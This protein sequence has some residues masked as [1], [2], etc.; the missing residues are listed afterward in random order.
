[1][2]HFKWFNSKTAIIVAGIL[3]SAYLILI[4]TVTNLGQSRLKESQNS[5]LNLR[6]SNYTENLSFF[7]DA[8][9]K[10]IANLSQ[11]R[12]VNTYFSNLAAGMSLQYGLGSSLF[13]LRRTID[14]F[15]QSNKMD[16]QLIYSRV[17]IVGLGETVIVDTHPEVDFEVNQL[18]FKEMETVSHKVHLVTDESGP[19]IQLLQ[20]IYHQNKPVAILVASLNTDLVIRMLSTQEHLD[21]GSCLTL[22]TPV[23]D[24]VVWNSLS[25]CISDIE[26]GTT[27]YYSDS[28]RIIYFE[29][30]VVATPFKLESWF[31]PVTEQDIF[32][33]AWFIAAISLLALPV[34]MGLIYLMRVNNANLV[35]Q[36]QVEL[37]SEQQQELATQNALLHEEICK[38]K[39]SESK[40]AYQ[41]THDE[42]TNLANRTHGMA[43]LQEAIRAAHEKQTQILLLFIDL[44]NFKQVND[45]V[46]HHAG[47]LLLKQTSERLLTSVRRSDIV[48]RLGGDEFLVIVPDI[49]HQDSAKL[50]ASSILSV[51]EKP[52]HIEQ[53]EFFVSTSIGMSIYPKDGRNAATLLKRADTALYKVK[54]LGRNGFS[55]YDESMNLDV[56]RNFALNVRLHQAVQ[57][58]DIEIYYQP[59][60]DLTSRKIVAAEAL[61]RWTDSEL[62]YV[63]PEDFIPL[64][65]KNGLIHRLGD[66]VLLEACTQ[67]ASWQT[68]SPIKIAINF[69]S[70]QFRYCEQLQSRIVDVLMQTGLPAY[71]L[72]MEVTESLLIDQGHALMKML[73]YLKQ[74]GVGLSIDDFGTGYSALSYLQR[75]SFTKLKIDRA[76][77]NNMTT[78]SSDASLVSAI[79][80]MAKSL[81]LKVVAE[82][83]EN[84]QQALF[85][86]E[87]RC[88]YGQGYL[89]SRP[90]PAAEFTQLLLRDQKDASLGQQVERVS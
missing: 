89:F 31:E 37:S 16:G 72:D 78:C 50:V 29:K 12:D 5:A 70:V 60:L 46:G 84:E 11:K 71:Q 17:M 47:D 20:T 75:F 79:L 24:I 28:S 45:T 13:S 35:L 19:V 44:D 67:A 83:I 26:R 73:S 76:F 9:E 36:T 80:A 38:R 88:E 61:M 77:I 55:F 69:S 23:G 14:N 59:I 3:L 54:D 40:L 41:A 25:G 57:Q 63:S 56:Q 82:G 6:V 27:S 66:I 85:L 42:L 52:F 7:F 43:R 58:G 81:K 68:I 87:H 30:N 34:F 1:M 39:A 65:E 90:V 62:G 18:P 74:L 15:S 53:Q 10:N 33:S 49:Q 48:A 51:F 22:V 2:K 32:T 64:A 86:Q 4:L 8:S 21:S